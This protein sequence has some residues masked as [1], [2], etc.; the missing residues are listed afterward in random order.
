MLM[1]L[2]YKPKWE[3]THVS[4]LQWPVVKGKSLKEEIQIDRDIELYQ[5]MKDLMSPIDYRLLILHQY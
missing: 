4:D 3:N 1:T 2:I 5:I